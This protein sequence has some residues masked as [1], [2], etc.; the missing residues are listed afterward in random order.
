MGLGLW[1]SAWA[2]P[3]RIPREERAGGPWCWGRENFPVPGKVLGSFQE[4]IPFKKQVSLGFKSVKTKSWPFGRE[5]L[6]RFQE[7]FQASR[8][9]ELPDPFF[10]GVCSVH[11]PKQLVSE[12]RRGSLNRKPC[13]GT[14]AYRRR[15]VNRGLISQ[16]STSVIL[17]PGPSLLT[18]S[19]LCPAPWPS[20]DLR[21]PFHAHP[22]RRLLAK[23]V[24][25]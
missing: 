10:S 18:G 20:S 25:D 13:A 22:E 3:T 16:A 11:F 9:A 12:G 15:R 5:G 1:G 6:E 23:P 14:R 17:K 7:T 8:S 19:D 24:R 4:E 21:L 2:L